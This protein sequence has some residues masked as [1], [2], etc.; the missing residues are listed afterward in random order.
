MRHRLDLQT[1]RAIVL[2]HLLLA[3]AVPQPGGHVVFKQ[4]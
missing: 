1:L 4:L 2:V 3:Y